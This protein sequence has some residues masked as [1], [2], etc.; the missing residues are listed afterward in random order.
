MPSVK[1][2]I[3]DVRQS[4]N[5][6]SFD[7]YLPAKFL[8]SKLL[9]AARLFIKREADDRRLYLQP[10]IWVTINAFEMEEV[11][12]IGCSD[13][14]VP[15]CTKVMKSILKLPQ[16]YSTRYGYLLNVSSIDYDKNYIQTT[17]KEYSS[18]VKLRYRNPKLRY[19][20]IYNNHLVIPNA[21][22]Q[23]VTLRAMFC[24]K[25]QGLKVEG[26]D[27][28]DCI[29]TLDQEFTVPGHLL[30]NVKDYVVMKIAQVRDRIP[31]DNY[32]D[33]NDSRKDSPQ[34]K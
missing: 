32:P 23:T 33:L 5:R 31:S 14:S 24:D 34:A 22:V 1:E 20:W 9:D 21:M 16:I 27:Q 18:I 15:Q 26:C 11:P 30:D 7:G 28:E 8:H 29:K 4:L 6:V 12:L 17:P 13:I 2:V 19:F 3:S 25:A 10:D